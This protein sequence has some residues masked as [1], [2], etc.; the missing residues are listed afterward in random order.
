MSLGLRTFRVSGFVA[1]LA[2]AIT[3]AHLLLR[4]ALKASPAPEEIPFPSGPQTALSCRTGLCPSES[5][6]RLSEGENSAVPCRG[7]LATRRLESGSGRRRSFAAILS[8]AFPESAGLLRPAWFL[9]CKALKGP[10]FS[11][12]AYRMGGFWL[13]AVTAFAFTRA[14]D[15]INRPAQQNQPA[16]ARARRQAPEVLDRPGKRQHKSIVMGE[17]SEPCHA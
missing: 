8:A 7:A 14:H 12:W 4:K 3:N 15:V 9:W 13:A 5:S 6:N 1:E 10:L 11:S 17:W 16:S 2:Q